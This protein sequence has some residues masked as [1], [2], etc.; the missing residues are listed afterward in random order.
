MHIY[1]Y[2]YICVC[3][4]YT[5]DIHASIVAIYIYMLIYVFMKL[6]TIIQY[7]NLS[8]VERTCNAMDGGGSNVGLYHI[9]L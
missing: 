3:V 1:I 5:H 4:I 2:I 6:H 8:G 9:T 7:I